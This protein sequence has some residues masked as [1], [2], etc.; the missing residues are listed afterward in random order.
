MCR[1]SGF[2]SQAKLAWQ[3]P[4]TPLEC[5]HRPVKIDAREGLHS[6]FV[7]KLRENR[8]PSAAN[9]SRFGV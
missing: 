5:G 7:Q 3:R 1:S 4:I 9:S 6:G 2:R 8:T